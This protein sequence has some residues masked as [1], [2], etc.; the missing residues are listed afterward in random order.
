MWISSE[1][2]NNMNRRQKIPKDQRI[3][4]IAWRLLYEQIKPLILAVYFAKALLL[5]VYFANRKLKTET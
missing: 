5:A 2:L 3:S 1:Q 4:K